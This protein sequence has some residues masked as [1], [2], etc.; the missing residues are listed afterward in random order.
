M[1]RSAFMPAK[2]KYAPPRI[3]VK[4]ASPLIVVLMGRFG[5]VML[6]VHPVFRKVDRLVPQL[7]K[8]RV[9]CPDVHCKLEL[10]DQA[11]TLH[12]RSNPAFSTIFESALW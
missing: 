9:I 8:V 1:W 12:E 3:V 6:K 2:K 11:R 5:L 4:A 10:P 7:V